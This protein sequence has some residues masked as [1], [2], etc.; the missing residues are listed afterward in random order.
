MNIKKGDQVKAIAGRDRGKTGKVLSV[1]ASDERVIVEGLHIVK[2]HVRPRREG[3]KGQ[4]VE[5][6]GK[7]NVSNVMLVCPKCG[8]ATRVSFIKTGKQKMRVCKK[9]KHE[10]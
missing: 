9:C 6:A 1:F 7:A 2:K 3:E 4:R 10:F 5:I 8:K